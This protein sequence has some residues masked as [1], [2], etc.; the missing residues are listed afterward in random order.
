[1]HLLDKKGLAEVRHE[2]RSLMPA[3]TVEML[4]ASEL[5]DLLAYLSSL[6]GE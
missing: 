5:R 4:N 3:Y 2:E 6:R 1:L